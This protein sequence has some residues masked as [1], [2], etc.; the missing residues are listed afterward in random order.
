[1]SSEQNKTKT[2]SKKQRPS[3][4]NIPIYHEKQRLYYCG[5][6]CLNNLFQSNV[7]SKRYLDHIAEDLW[8]SNPYSEARSTKSMWTSVFSN[9]FNFNPH[10]SALG[11]GM[12]DENV[13]LVALKE[14]NAEGIRFDRRKPV[15]KESLELDRVFGFI[16]NI[17]PKRSLSG[18][19]WYSI[20]Y[21]NGKWYNLDSSLS[22]PIPLSS[23]SNDE[24]LSNLLEFMQQEVTKYDAEIIKVFRQGSDNQ[25]NYS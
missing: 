22:N 16:V 8:R 11:M 20:R 23:D 2:Y 25:T 14:M 24:D 21:I 1:M 19:H 15:T 4:K 9:L 18:R 5:I 17:A 3:P 7:F 12:Y 6:H 10:K 13:V